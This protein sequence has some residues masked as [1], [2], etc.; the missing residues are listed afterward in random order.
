MF[1]RPLVVGDGR[2]EARGQQPPPPQA[3]PIG[4]LGPRGLELGSCG[5]HHRRIQPLADGNC[6]TTDPCVVDATVHVAVLLTAHH[7]TGLTGR[8]SW[9]GAV[10]YPNIR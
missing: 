1:F 3:G 7:P 10:T 8:E 2:C 9:P 6:L 4:A 5:C